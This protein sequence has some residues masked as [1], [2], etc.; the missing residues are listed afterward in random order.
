MEETTAIIKPLQL[1]QK[2]FGRVRRTS[3]E[4]TLTLHER[5]IS[6]LPKLVKEI[7]ENKL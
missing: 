4:T 7:K 5:P 3:M 2:V 1:A 6:L